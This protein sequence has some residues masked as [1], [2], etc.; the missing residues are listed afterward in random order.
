MIKKKTNIDNILFSL[1]FISLLF[2][3]IS[4]YSINLFSITVPFL[5]TVIIIV[6]KLFFTPNMVIETRKLVVGL[7]FGIVVFL[8][9]FLS[10]E[11]INYTSILLY[12]YFLIFY[13]VGNNLNEESS[14]IKTI[15]LFIKI[16]TLL[17]IYAVYQFVAYNFFTSLPLKEI[18]PAALRTPGYNTITVAYVG[19]NIFYRAHSI[20]LEPSTLSQ[21]SSMIV[22]LI[23]SKSFDSGTSFKK[24][25]IP[26]FIN[27]L[28]LF[29]SFSGS[30]LIVLGFGI[31]YLFAISHAFRKRIFIFFFIGCIAALALYPTGL[32]EQLVNYYSIRSLEFFSFYRTSGYYRFIVPLLA[33]GYVISN[34][35][36]GFGAGNDEILAHLLNSQEHG[37]P[38]GFGKI[39][40]DF[41]ILGLIL[42]VILLF[43]L[44]PQKNSSLSRRMLFV[45]L[46]AFCI[47]GSSILL[48]SFWCI[49]VMTGEKKDT[50]RFIEK[51]R[52][53]AE[54][55]V[56]FS[57]Q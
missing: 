34:K 20:Y 8:T 49:S 16:G 29:L 9:S 54:D 4:F 25:I 14:H 33:L 38:N 47:C 37:I 24:W 32:F 48:V 17:S 35:W 1:L 55:E 27:L 40:A 45:L 12:F 57:L 52:T 50:K 15:N 28:A 56:S 23:I 39:I 53:I 3:G 11:I 10:G 51:N 13:I 2:E 36:F 30:G 7:C 18:I 26:V 43:T 6:K 44:K 21:I 5:V 31:V 41:G 42:F 22:L 46:I 19:N